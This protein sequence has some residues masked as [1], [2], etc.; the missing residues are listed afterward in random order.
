VKTVWNSYVYWTVYE[1]VYETAYQAAYDAI[2]ETVW[3][4]MDWNV[5]DE[6]VRD[7]VDKDMWGGIPTHWDSWGGI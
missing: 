2:S 4:F 1:A 7:T 3:D 6:F 5:W